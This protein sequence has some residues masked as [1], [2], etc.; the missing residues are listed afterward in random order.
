M[1]Q[2]KIMKLKNLSYLL[3]VVLV[4][5]CFAFVGNV[6]ADN[7]EGMKH[8]KEAHDNG[9]TLEVHIYDNGKVL[10]RGAK[11]TGVAGNVISAYTTWGSVTLNW[12]V[13]ADAGAKIIRKYGGIS[14]ISEIS[15]GDF[16][17]FHGNMVTTVGSPLTVNAD[18]VKDWSIQNRGASMNGMVK[19]VD[20]A[21]M[22]F[23]LS[24]EDK[25]D[26][27]VMVTSSTKIMKGDAVGV[28]ADITVGA[29]V[30]V[31]GTL[32][33]LT[34]TLTAD[35]V[36]VNVPKVERTVVGGTIKSL[37]VTASPMTLV[38][39]SGD[40]DYTVNIA[41]DASILNALWLRIS[42]STLRVGDSVQVYGMVNTN[43]TIDATVVRDTT[44]R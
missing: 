9:S 26:V 38:M 19:S 1:A 23:V 20:S 2:I 8:F 14:S 29:K 16:I 25:A 15:V 35:M 4:F 32:N 34:N 41:S 24:H 18:I 37:S 28:F 27:T 21:G 10:V 11:V 33:T 43:M 42:L 7:D 13:N 39:T 44:L 3:A 12:A 40:K 36:K 31:R 30:S 5:S 17:S 22:K 6:K